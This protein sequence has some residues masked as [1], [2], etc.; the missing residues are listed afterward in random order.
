[1]LLENK[2]YQCLNAKRGQT[3]EKMFF[4]VVAYKKKKICETLG[5]FLRAYFAEEA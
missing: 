3:F 1:V 4:I 2:S 5:R